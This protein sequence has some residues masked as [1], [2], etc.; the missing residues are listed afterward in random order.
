MNVKLAI[1][2]LS[3]IDEVEIVVSAR[4]NKNYL[5]DKAKLKSITISDDS[6]IEVLGECGLKIYIPLYDLKE[7]LDYSTSITFL[8]SNIQILFRW[9]L[10]IEPNEGQGELSRI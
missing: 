6:I 7:I 4:F 8:T 3:K 5:G 9:K 10:P 2:K 1:S